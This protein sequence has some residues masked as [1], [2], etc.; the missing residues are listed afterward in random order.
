MK[1]S[2]IIEL[3]KEEMPMTFSGRYNNKVSPYI[4]DHIIQV[5][6]DRFQSVKARNIKNK[7]SELI[8]HKYSLMDWVVDKGYATEE[9][10]YDNPKKMQQTRLNFMD[11]LIKYYKQI[12]D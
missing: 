3:A 12:G 2:Q 10:I 7:I 11:D 4:C 6:T 5:G 1:S 8:G 9:E